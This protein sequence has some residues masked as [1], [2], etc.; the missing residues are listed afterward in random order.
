MADHI[1]EEQLEEYKEAFA[2]FDRNGD[3]SITTKVD[4]I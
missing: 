3:G 4:P 1:K 2:M